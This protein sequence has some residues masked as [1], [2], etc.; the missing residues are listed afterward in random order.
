MTYASHIR[1]SHRLARLR[2]AAP[3]ERPVL[4]IAPAPLH[5][6]PPAPS[7]PAPGSVVRFE[8]RSCGTVPVT[9]RLDGSG[10]LLWDGLAKILGWSPGTALSVT[11]GPGHW[12][13]LRSAG[14]AGAHDRRRAHVDDKGRLVVPK[15]V[16]VYLAAGGSTELVLRPDAADGTLHLAHASVLALALDVLARVE[17]LA[18]PGS[19][20]TPSSPGSDAGECAAG[21]P[22]RGRRTP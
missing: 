7:G 10:R 22:L 18:A 20:A 11:T 1:D 16:R 14:T 3:D 12:V 6:R 17:T 19:P 13:T 15:G 4:P 8:T 2:P 5:E 9:R 21:T